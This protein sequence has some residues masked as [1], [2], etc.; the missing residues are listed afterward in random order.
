MSS[1]PSGSLEGHLSEE[2]EKVAMEA[3]AKARGKSGRKKKP[4]ETEKRLMASP[5]AQTVVKLDNS[6]KS[7]SKGSGSPQH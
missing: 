6:S 3:I 1:A 4:S 7:P 2:A 5:F